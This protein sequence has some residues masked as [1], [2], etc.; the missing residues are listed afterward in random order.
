M[1]TTAAIGVEVSNKVRTQ[2]LSKRA[3]ERHALADVV[4]G[5]HYAD[6]T[7]IARIRANDREQQ[8]PIL[9]ECTRSLRV[10]RWR[11]DALSL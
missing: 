4:L 8:V 6:Q 1:T 7:G 10:I 9:N 2:R 5:R 11:V 3:Q